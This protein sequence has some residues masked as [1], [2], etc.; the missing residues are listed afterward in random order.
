VDEMGFFWLGWIE[1]T[2]DEYR[3]EL[4]ERKAREKSQATAT[5]QQQD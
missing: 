2:E 3:K 1:L 5:T 4:A